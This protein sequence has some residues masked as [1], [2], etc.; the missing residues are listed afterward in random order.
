MMYCLKIPYEAWQ[1]WTLEPSVVLK[2]FKQP[3][4]NTKAVARICLQFSRIKNFA[5]N[6]RGKGCLKVVTLLAAEKASYVSA[7]WYHLNQEFIV[8]TMV[9][10]NVIIDFSYLLNPC[11]NKVRSLSNF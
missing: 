6:S 7:L 5:N 11:I 9:M 2:H 1:S 8:Y 4:L 10:L 3:F